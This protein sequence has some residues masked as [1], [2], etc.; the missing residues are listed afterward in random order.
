MILLASPL[1]RVVGGSGSKGFRCEGDGA[2]M[3]TRLS[4]IDALSLHT[5]SSQTPAHTLTLV[6]IDAS[7]QLS[8]QRLHQLVAA[9]LPQLARFR[10]RL[11]TK[12][13]GVGQPVWAQIDDYDPSPQIHCATVRAPGGRREFADLIADLTTGQPDCRERLWEAWSINGLAG[14]RWALA[15]KMSPALNDRAAGAASVWPRLLSTGPRADL[16]NG[17]PTEPSLGSAPSV[18]ELVTDVVTEMVENYVTGVWLIAETVSGVLHA[19]RGRL[20]GTRVGGRTIP[21]VSSMSGPVP[22]T[23]FNAPLTKRRAVAFASI[24]LADVKMVSDA[25]GGSIT[26]VVL[27]AC[28]L[29]LRAWLQRHDKVPDDPLLMRMPFEL[30][31]TDPPRIGKAWTVGRLRIPVHLADP[32]QVLANLHTATERLNAIR[33]CCNESAAATIDLDTIASLIPPTI[34][35]LGMRLYTRSGLWRQLQPICHGS[36]SYNAV[37]PMPA[38]CA[39][40]KVV[41]MHTVAPLVEESGLNIALTSRGEELDVSVC[42]CPDNVPAV[43]DIATGIVHAVD[44]LMAA[45][46]ESPRGQGRSVVTQMTSHPANRARRRPH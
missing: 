25:F 4:G 13:L 45:A 9:S 36:V 46:R 19:V 42:A 11:V 29:S 33:S 40:G 20:L 26:N 31:A 30:P 10:S 44:I 34:A 18:G 2:L 38:Y 41:G 16:A 28:T 35:H 21:P 22:H 3:V 27:A 1:V 5:Q 8:H 17:L 23:V 43:D 24:R 39:G 32:V 6:I 7:D 37:E 12:P 14:G 15:V